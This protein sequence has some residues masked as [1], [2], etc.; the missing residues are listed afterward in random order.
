M[1]RQEWN[2]FGF[3]GRLPSQFLATAYRAQFHHP[4]HAWSCFDQAKGQYPCDKGRDA[5]RRAQRPHPFESD[6]V[7]EI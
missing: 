6:Y 2:S 7:I 1:G 5:F 4:F 3:V